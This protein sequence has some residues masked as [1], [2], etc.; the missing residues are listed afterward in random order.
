L[1][2]S[3]GAEWL[4]GYQFGFEM[5]LINGLLI[6]MLLVATSRGKRMVDLRASDHAL[7]TN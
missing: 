6:F 1:L 7:K 2:D 4:N 5:L 3:R